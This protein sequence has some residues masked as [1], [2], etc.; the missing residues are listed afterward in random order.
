MPPSQPA[1]PSAAPPK[2]EGVAIESPMVGT[3]Y[4]SPDPESPPFI[5]VGDKVTPDTVVCI[6]EA[7]KV[8]SEIKAE[9]SGT[10]TEISVNNGDAVEYGQVLFRVKP[11]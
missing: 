5:N 4:G 6:V 3:F 9:C 1:P 11:D 10:V 8:F 7:M 2:G